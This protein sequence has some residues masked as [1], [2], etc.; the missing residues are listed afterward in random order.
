MIKNKLWLRHNV[1]SGLVMGA[2]LAIIEFGAFSLGM[3]FEPFLSNIFIIISTFSV[4]TAIRNYRNKELGGFISIGNAFL[5]GFVVCVVAGAV[6]S[7][8]R[9]FQYHFSPAIVQTII[10]SQEEVL[11]A[12]SYSKDFKE[13]LIQFNKHTITPQT[14]AIINTFFANMVIGGSFLSLLLAFA[15]KREKVKIQNNTK[16]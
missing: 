3:L 12:S 9:Y 4:F 16:L 6:W 8:Y 10:D 5:I 2:S 1:I 14:L 15:L 13:L 7:V 11:I